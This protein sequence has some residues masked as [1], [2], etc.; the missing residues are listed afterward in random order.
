MRRADN[1]TVCC[2]H[3]TKLEQMRHTCALLVMIHGRC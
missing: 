1:L 3:K 2:F